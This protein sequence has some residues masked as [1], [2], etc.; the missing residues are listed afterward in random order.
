M[1]EFVASVRQ[2]IGR[3]G[4]PEEACEAIRPSFAELLTD[5]ECKKGARFDA[6]PQG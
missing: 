4:S 6:S 5:A 2:N 1:R 3:D